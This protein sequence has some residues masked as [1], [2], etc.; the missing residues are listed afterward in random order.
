M[1]ISG[2][3]FSAADSAIGYLY[4]ARTALL[5]ALRRL[6]SGADF[7]VSLET[8]DDVTF[9]ALDG[10][11][12]QLLQTKHHRNRE[13]NLTDASPDLWKSL[14]IWLET[15][16]SGQVPDGTLF[17]L[18]TTAEA[19]TGSIA[20]ML[21]T[22]S[23]DIDGALA[24]LE[25]TAQT[26]TNQANTPAYQIFLNTP[27]ATR[28]NVFKDVFVIDSSKSITDLDDDLQAVLFSAVERNRIVPFLVRLEGWWLHRVLS[29]LTKPGDRILADEIESQ[30]SDLREQ[31]QR[32]SLPI[33]SDLLDF[34]LDELTKASHAE[35][36]FVHQIELTKASKER[37]FAAVRDYYRAFEQRSRWLRED[38]LFV[39][40]LN[41]YERH[42]VEEWELAF[43]A[44]KDK[45]GD[46]ATEQ[47]K[48]RLA[49]DLLEWAEQ[50]A[51]ARV[52][53]R[54]R[55]TEPFVTRGSLHMLADTMQIGWHPEF[56]DRLSVLLQ[57]RGRVA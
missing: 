21:R 55:V 7:C 45:C 30:M 8:L 42:L 16:A 9:E 53:I 54:P 47:A 39:G 2:G 37:I 20:Y 12:Q 43:A 13:A 5:W 24:A 34:S 46:A 15:H 10:S 26:S 14:R 18:L 48:E 41:K 52:N 36:I 23:H 1:A 28:R 6:P 56:R 35:S 11:P 33:D 57:S 51:P 44:M 22:T 38:L 27:L 32:G 17:Y 49:R 50:V 40:D 31:F 3:S 25:R 4:Q 19:L 29:Q